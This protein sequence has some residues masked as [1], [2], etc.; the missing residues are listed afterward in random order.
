MTTQRINHANHLHDAT[1][2]ARAQCRKDMAAWDAGLAARQAKAMVPPHPDARIVTDTNG[3]R[4]W[5]RSAP[6]NAAPVQLDHRVL[7][8]GEWLLIV[9]SPDVI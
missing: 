3:H 9:G 6:A 7:I 4:Y 1:P 8:D 2:A 5:A